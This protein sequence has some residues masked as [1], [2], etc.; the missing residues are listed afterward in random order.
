MP[1]FNVYENSL[2]ERFQN[3]RKKIQLYGGGF[4]NG[5]TA[6]LC[7][8]TLKVAEGYPGANILLAR[9]TYPKLN[10]TLRKEFF[11]WCPSDWIKNFNKGDNEVTLTNNTMINF[12]YVQQQAKTEGSTSNL[13]SAT[14][15]LVV[16]DQ[17]ED[18]EIGYKDFL[19][20]LGRLRGSTPYRGN[21]PTMPQSG[22][23][24]LVLSCNPSRNWLY[25]NIV[26]PIHIYNAN[27]SK[28]PELLVNKQTGEP[29]V[30]LFEGST[31]ENKD[32]LDADY[33]D[34][35]EQTYKGQMRERFLLGNWGAY[36][37]L[38]YP[39]YNALV[40]EVDESQVKR[41]KEV[42]EGLGIQLNWIEGYDYGMAVPACYLA[43]FVDD[44]ANVFIVDGFY[45]TELTI[46]RSA[47][48][49]K[50][51]RDKWG[52]GGTNVHADPQIFRRT[53]G[54]S[55]TVGQ[56]IAG[57]F[58]DCGI[59]MQ[60]GNN[61]IANGIIKLQSYLAIN[62]FHA[63]PMLHSYPAPRLYVSTK[64]PFVSNEFSEYYWK[65]DTGGEVTDKP[66]DKNDHAL[67]TLKYMFSDQPQLA[68]IIVKHEQRPEWTQ[69]HEFERE[70]QKSKARNRV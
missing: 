51:I 52:F 42:C 5:K 37:G 70:A 10:D 69:W 53:V 24:W 30:D 31:Y 63:H 62:E 38:V 27:G 35:L 65:R 58:S 13:L 43:G 26:K 12:R 29:L 33:I 45:E 18:P 44:D 15:D 11:K 8:K 1:V 60:R 57:L 23:R 22:P 32:N 48:Q 50:A 34:T 9:A 61:D 41:Y 49:I 17:M 40:H 47:N 3:S 56:S 28:S 39:E 21:D 59:E 67:D 64:V 68:S 46:E 14:Y 7:I 6:N 4:A 55:K 19:D 2:Q 54:N 16:V 36:E 20:L 66:V 25:R